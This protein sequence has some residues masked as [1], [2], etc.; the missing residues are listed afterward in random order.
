MVEVLLREPVGRNTCVRRS[1]EDRPVT[2]SLLTARLTASAQ[3]TDVWI[4]EILW[5]APATAIVFDPSSHRQW[6][7]EVSADAALTLD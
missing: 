3:D 2:V 5:L 7:L 6:P 1:V 4:R